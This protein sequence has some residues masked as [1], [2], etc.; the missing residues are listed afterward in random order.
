[1]TLEKPSS[2][3]LAVARV[4]YINGQA[5]AQ[6]MAAVERL[7]RALGL[8][9]R[10]MVRWGE[11]QLHC[12]DDGARLISEVSA[13]PSGVDMDRVASTMRTIEHIEAGRIAPKAMAKTQSR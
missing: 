6:I 5:T 13:D 11:L 1:M 8:R 3:V 2:L 10:I 9:A 7:G 12:E 4:L